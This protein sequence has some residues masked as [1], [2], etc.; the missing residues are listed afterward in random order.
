[1]SETLQKM[2]KEN[3]FV[4]IS[5]NAVNKRTKTLEGMS[6]MV[7]LYVA[8]NWINTDECSEVIAYATEQLTEEA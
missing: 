2:S 5:A 7:A 8:M 4:R 3:I 6:E 1:M